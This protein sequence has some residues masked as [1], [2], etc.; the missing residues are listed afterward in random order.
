MIFL[1]IKGELD[2]SELEIEGER[3]LWIAHYY[4]FIPIISRLKYANARIISITSSSENDENIL[5]YY[6]ELNSKSCIVRVR[7]INLAIESIIPFFHS[8]HII[9]KEIN[10]VFNVSFMN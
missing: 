4:S 1:L 2:F 6:F 7:T 3:I 8:A 9:E 10:S 5:D